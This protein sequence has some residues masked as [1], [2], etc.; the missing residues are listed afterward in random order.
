VAD[1]ALLEGL[2]I[3]VDLD[4]R[5]FVMPTQRVPFD[6]VLRVEVKVD[7]KRGTVGAGKRDPPGTAWSEVLVDAVLVTDDRVADPRLVG[8]GLR[9]YST[10]GEAPALD[11]E[12]LRRRAREVAEAAARVCGRKVTG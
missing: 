1:L 5:A 6:S 3:E 12:P 10:D 11:A 8:L 4:G 9:S 7:E 2:S